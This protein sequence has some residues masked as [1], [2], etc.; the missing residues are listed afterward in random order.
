MLLN[1]DLREF[2]ASLNSNKVEYLVVGAFALAFHGIYR[3]TAD[4]D[5]LVNR[6]LENA[7]RVIRAIEQF[8]L[9]SLGVSVSDLSTQDQI[10][11]RGVEPNRIDLITS[12]TGVT[13]REAWASRVAGEIDGIPT[14]YIGRGE[15]IRNKEVTG[16]PR[17][18]ADVDE[19]KKRIDAKL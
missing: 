10:V 5:L 11:Q 16:R 13:F 2:I 6:T 9:G 7:A 1:S 14:Q 19:L 4:L 15:L 8:G 17:D 18:L 3:Y 12:I